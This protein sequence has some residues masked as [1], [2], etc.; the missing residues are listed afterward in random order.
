MAGARDVLTRAATQATLTIDLGALVENWRGLAS[1][2]EPAECAA[3]VKADAYGIGLEPAVVALARAGCRTFFV[4]H[5]SEGARARAALGAAG[6]HR[7][8]VLNGLTP[9]NDTLAALVRDRLRPVLGSLEQARRWAA[10]AHATTNAPPAALQ[11]DSGMNRL[12]AAPEQLDE[13]AAIEGLAI[14]HVMSHFVA[15][16]EAGE[17]VN[18]RQIAVFKAAREKFPGI[19]ASLA[20]SSGILLPQMPHF[21]LVRPGYAL[22][23]GNPAPGR[24]NPM[25]HV[26][27]LRAPVIQTRRIAA[28]ETVGYNGQWT[29]RRPSLLAT[30][31]VG[32]A[33]GLPRAL[34]STD[35]RAGGEAMVLG[36]RCPFAGRVSMDLT[37]IDVTDVSGEVAP[38]T[39]VELLGADI[40]VDDMGARAGTIGYEVLT[41]LGRRYFRNYVGG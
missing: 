9:D 20:N 33:D 13:I 17:A 32:Y 15:S 30:I 12:G 16:E 27:T 21:D 23:G 18:D 6:D 36:H 10:F 11:I 37:V 22:Y 2:A 5:V 38:G 26:V 25:R 28:G 35:D 39:P 34:M 3:V 24:P 14:D 40:T 4:A 29:A 19:A 41:S 7:I 1:V 31:G 8:Y